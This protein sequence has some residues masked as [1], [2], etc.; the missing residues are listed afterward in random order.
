MDYKEI[1]VYTTT[2]G[3]DI[4]SGYLAMQGVKGVVIEDPDDFSEFLSNTE[5]HWDYV[6]E[7]LMARQNTEANLKFYLP[8][9][10][11][12]VKMLR[13]IAAGLGSLQEQN[14]AVDLGRLATEAARVNEEDWST[15]WKK[16][17]HPT[18]VGERLVVVP[19]WE[20]YSPARDEVVLTLDPG[21]AF[22]TGTHETTRLCMR[23][24]EECVKRGDAVLDIGTGSG[25]LAI[26]ALL[27]GAGSAEGVDI[28]E[29]AVKI[30]GEN[31]KLN[32]VSE[33]LSLHCGDLTDTVSGQFDVLC[34]N[35]VADVIIRLCADVVRFM[36][37]G[38]I[39][40][41]S[42]IIEERCDEVKAALQEAGLTIET[43]CTE[44]G[45]A[46]IKAVR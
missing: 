3:I 12:G 25:I 40:V 17:Y 10:I 8:E 2:A 43:I 20:K 42:G 44:N 39:L 36:H 16:Y 28:D 23:L 14:P 29:L 30:A 41:V 22:G 5:I 38:S 37:V 18:K 11:Q 46:A 33:R 15:A 31:A 24:L 32:G 13:Q 45:W 35:I 19:C 27:L 21:M 34:A 7:P 9:N 4:V 26:T 6:D 1:T